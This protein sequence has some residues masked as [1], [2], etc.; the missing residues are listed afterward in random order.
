MN[1]EQVLRTKHEE[2]MQRTR[3]Y[4]KRQKEAWSTFDWEKNEVETA[5]NLKHAMS[6]KI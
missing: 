4:L 6:D 1:K 3:E 5:R 2:R